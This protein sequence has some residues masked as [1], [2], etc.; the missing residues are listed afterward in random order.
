M[1]DVE[2]ASDDDKEIEINE[3][4]DTSL[5]SLH[6]S[7]F[8]N[9]YGMQRFGTRSISTHQVGLAM[10]AGAWETAVD[11]VMMPKGDERPEYVE[12]RNFWME[13]RDYKQ[14][15]RVFPRGCVA[16]RA[17]LQAMVKRQ[18]GDDYFG[19]LQAVCCL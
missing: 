4:L 13:K 16:E 18:R 8:I 14:A 9:Y 19:A 1:R 2:F 5:N 3:V 6:N 17:I 12:A 10:L 7:G 11:L 15:L